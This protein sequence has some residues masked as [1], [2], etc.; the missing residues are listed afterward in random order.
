MTLHISICAIA[1]MACAAVWAAAAAEE[2][3]RLVPNLDDTVKVNHEG[4]GGM[5]L[6]N[7]W[8]TPEWEDL[9]EHIDD[10]KVVNVSV[11]DHMN[12]GYTATNLS[13]PE[14]Y[15]EW[16]ASTTRAKLGFTSGES[17]QARG[18]SAPTDE[19]MVGHERGVPDPPED[20][21]GRRVVY[22]WE[23]LNGQIREFD[24]ARVQGSPSMQ[25]E[26][27]MEMV[28]LMQREMVLPG[29]WFNRAQLEF[30]WLRSCNRH[31]AAARM[32]R[33]KLRQF[34]EPELNRVAQSHL[35]D[36][37]D[38]EGTEVHPGLETTEEAWAD[39][40]FHALQRLARRADV[41]ADRSGDGRVLCPGA[42]PEGRA[43]GS[44]SSGSSTL[45][46]GM[47]HARHIWPDGTWSSR[48]DLIAAGRY[49]LLPEEPDQEEN[50]EVEH[51]PSQGASSSGVEGIW[52]DLWSNCGNGLRRGLPRTMPL[53]C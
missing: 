26:A 32:L 45:P 13:V 30:R 51:A 43:T 2:L 22:S 23:L 40:V 6:A 18:R 10:M 31:A 34:R 14:Q 4:R 28:N 17:C 44:A 37:F 1:W 25:G 21:Q 9:G 11:H 29:G 24:M 49:D 3:N 35:R 39:F 5:R 7:S 27:E 36:L 15:R 20:E 41:E 33:D 19:G 47:M 46:Y 16:Q 50:E 52:A 38:D 12:L 42:L 53:Q 8:P 48:E